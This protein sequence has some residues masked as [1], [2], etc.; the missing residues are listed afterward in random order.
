M[1]LKLN[2]TTIMKKKVIEKEFYEAPSFQKQ[3]IILEQ[4]IAAG[5]PQNSRGE[6]THEWNEEET[7]ADNEINFP[8]YL[9]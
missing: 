2:G 8:T 3:Q 9:L 1:Y 4:A 7:N 6:V 5:S